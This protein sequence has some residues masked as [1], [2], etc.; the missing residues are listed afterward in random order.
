[1]RIRAWIA[2]M[3]VLALAAPAGA[4]LVGE[5]PDSPEAHVDPN[6]STSPFAG[7]VGIFVAG[8]GPATGV[9]LRTNDPTSSYV[10]S[11][12]HTVD[13]SRNHNVSAASDISV[14]VN[15]T[16][17]SSTQLGVTSIHINPD[18]YANSSSHD[19][20][21]IFKLNGVVPAG[22]PTYNLY[23]TQPTTVQTIA[24]VGY[25][26][27]GTGTTGPTIGNGVNVKRFGY[28]QADVGFLDDDGGSLI[29]YY[30]FD[31]DNPAG[32]NGPTGGPSLGN[33]YEV[34]FGVGDSGGPAFVTGPNSELL[35]YGINTQGFNTTS[36]NFPLY[37]SVGG[38]QIVSAYQSFIDGIVPIPEPGSL[39]LAAVTGIGLLGRRLRISRR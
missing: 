5:S 26:Q 18:W 36:G 21:V 25:G 8:V 9:L 19:D 29:E 1:M 24:I 37:G 17:N 28:N 3:G 27:S 23:R 32:G 13:P 35:I 10:L 7:V 4:V 20:L 22:V 15:Y 34:Q 6:V 12:A 14:H 2:G 33:Q 38:G 11:A 31:F 30:Q 16:G 39:G